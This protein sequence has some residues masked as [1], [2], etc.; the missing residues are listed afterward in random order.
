MIG[1]SRSGEG[2]ADHCCK[3]RALPSS[4]IPR[5]GGH[6]RDSGRAAPV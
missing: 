2:I 6:R 5:P 3:T 4:T 1:G